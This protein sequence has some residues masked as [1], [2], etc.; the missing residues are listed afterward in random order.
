MY[1]SVLT[2]V[3]EIAYKLERSD[4]I[5]QPERER[6]YFLLFM[7]SFTQGG[8]FTGWLHTENQ[9]LPSIQFW[10]FFLFKFSNGPYLTFGTDCICISTFLIGLLSH[11]NFRPLISFPSIT[12]AHS[13][14]F[15]FLLCL[16][17]WDKFPHTHQFSL[18]PSDKLEP[19]TPTT[20]RHA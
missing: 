3:E 10:L 12:A 16:L 11:I 15:F 2:N 6:F 19:N 18:T 1:K 17:A 5:T 9:S 4:L 14:F 20:R 13:L 7:H 8:N